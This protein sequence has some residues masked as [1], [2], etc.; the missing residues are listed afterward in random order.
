MSKQTTALKRSN[1]RKTA[2][3]V[4]PSGKAAAIPNAFGLPAGKQGS[5]ISATEY[6]SEICYAGNTSEVAFPSVLRLVNANFEL[7][8]DASRAEMI[9]LLDEMIS[10]FVADC[11]KR[12]APQNFRIHW[13]GDFFSPIYVTAWAEI[14]K[15]FPTVQFWVYTRVG[16][17]ATYLHAQ[18]LPNLSLYFSADRDNVD[19]ARFVE[20]LG[21]NIAYVGPTF[22]DGKAAFPGATRCP[23]NNGAL[24]LITAQGSACQ[25]CGLCIHGRKSVLFSASKS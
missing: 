19:V 13:D 23:E 24:P 20:S 9:T 2:N 14:C 6:C 11:V 15:R 18:R 12:N 22:S 10:A 1:D 16:T 8:R 25:R 3:A 5:C 7:L 4:L 21:I 17:A